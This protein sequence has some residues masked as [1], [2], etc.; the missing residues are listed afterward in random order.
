MVVVVAV[1]GLLAWRAGRAD[2]IV[3]RC[4]ERVRVRRAWERAA[5]DAGVADGSAAMVRGV[6]VGARGGGR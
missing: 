4:C 3:A 1:G 6:R 5:I 2:R